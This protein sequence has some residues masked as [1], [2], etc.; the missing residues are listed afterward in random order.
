VYTGP[1]TLDATTVVKFV[2]VA[3]DGTEETDQDLA[4]YVEADPDTI[5]GDWAT[6]GHGHISA[7]AFRHWDPDG[8]VDS[9]ADGGCAKC[10]GASAGPDTGFLQ[11]AATGANADTAPLPLGLDC[12]GCHGD[13]NVG[14]IYALPGMYPEVQDVLFP[15]GAMADYGNPSNLCMTCHQGRESGSSVDA[16]DPNDAVQDPTD[17]D[18]F[19]FIN[20][21]YFAAAATLFGSDVGGGYEY[22]FEPGAGGAGGAPD[23]VGENTFPP[24]AAG[25]ND[26]IACHLNADSADPNRHTFMPEVANCG[27]CHGSPPASFPELGGTPGANY[28]DIQTLLPELLAAIQAYANTGLPQASP[29]FYDPV[30]YPYWFKEGGP[31]AYPN[32]YRDFDRQ[33]LR[34]AYNYQTGQKDPG[35]Y[36]HNGTYIKQLLIDSITDLG[37]TPSVTRP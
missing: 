34:A 25:L 14:T 31:A 13:F 26:C 20:I 22:P 32:R 6:S 23:Y 21:H 2:A 16:A 19:D 35:G 17:Y 28:D 4:G 27:P 11:Y 1:I 37:G 10:H 8:A 3:A 5:R 33:M 12:V 29:V 30:A 36:I 15:S 7:D 18:S 24:H 9:D